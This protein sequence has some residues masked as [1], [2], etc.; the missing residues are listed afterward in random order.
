[1]TRLCQGRPAGINRGFIALG[2]ARGLLYFHSKD[3]VWFD[4]KP[5]NVLLNASGDIAKI[6]DFGLARVLETI[7]IMT[8]QVSRS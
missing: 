6:A 1:M 8:H 4:C 7:C 3:I 2:I 5:G